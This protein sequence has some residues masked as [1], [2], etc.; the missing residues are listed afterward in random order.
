M[1]DHIN[2]ARRTVVAIKDSVVRKSLVRLTGTSPVS[3]TCQIP[4]IRELYQRLGLHPKAGTFVEIGGYDGEGFSNTS[5]LAD[6][7]WR[8]IYVEPVSERC[9]TI[10]L[11]HMF[12][13]VVVEPVA[14][15]D[16]DGDCEIRVM[17]ALSTLDVETAS[18]YE[19][20]KWGKKRASR[21]T[22]R[23]IRMEKLDF[24]LAR[25]AVPHDVELMIIDVEGH[26]LPVVVALMAGPWR[27]RVLIVELVDDH[28]D[29]N[30]FDTLKSN[31]RK[32]RQL[33]E[34][35]GYTAVY[36]DSVNTI[37]TIGAQAKA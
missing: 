3:R 12:N 18:A 6:Q 29:F 23:T 21:A 25:N 8:G 7:G 1:Q 19:H 2:Y 17:G 34:A 16:K 26:E 5:F 32:A 24:I 37:F 22:T 20:I 14:A 36:S 30:S 13:D 31:A 33:I 10:R 4:E 35:G 28:A 11:R 15:S 9:R 27:P